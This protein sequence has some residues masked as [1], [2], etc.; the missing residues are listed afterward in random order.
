[1]EVGQEVYI[2]PDDTRRPPFYTT[3]VSIG[4]KYITVKGPSDESRFDLITHR[5]INYNNWS[6]RLT[7]YESKEAYEIK[8]AADNLV[9]Q[10]LDDIQLKLP[11]ASIAKLFKIKDIL[12]ET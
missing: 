3:V 10:L 5:A 12:Y 8:V 9:K 4:R 7:L 1:M 2:V 6:P 11:K